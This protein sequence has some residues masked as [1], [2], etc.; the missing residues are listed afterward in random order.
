MLPGKP[1]RFKLVFIGTCLVTYN[2]DRKNFETLVPPKSP[3]VKR[4]AAT[5]KTQ[6]VYILKHALPTHRVTRAGKLEFPPRPDFLFGRTEDH[7]G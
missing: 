3:D 2:T 4:A 7:M 6:Q 1:E 5:A